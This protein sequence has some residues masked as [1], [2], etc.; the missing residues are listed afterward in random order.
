MV[1]A[2]IAG[3]AI[4]E[5]F[6]R[7]VGEFESDRKMIDLAAQFVNKFPQYSLLEQVTTRAGDLIEIANRPRLKARVGLR[8]LPGSLKS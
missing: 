2:G 7:F 5:P 6:L 8:V 4:G 1:T 3:A